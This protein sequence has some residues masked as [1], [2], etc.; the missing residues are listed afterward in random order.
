MWRL[1]GRNFFE[2]IVVVLRLDACIGGLRVFT[3][4][5]SNA[6][7]AAL[8][9]EAQ[10]RLHGEVGFLPIRVVD[11]G[12]LLTRPVSCSSSFNITVEVAEDSRDF[13]FFQA[14]REVANI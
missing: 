9:T 7:G 14:L 13:I 11:E 4:T 1:L 12:D 8:E 10:T 2:R 3:Q 5:E 6:F